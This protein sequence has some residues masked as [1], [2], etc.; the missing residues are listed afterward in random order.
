[1]MDRSI[2]VVDDNRDFAEL[3]GEVLDEE[4]YQVRVAFDGAAALAEIEHEHPDLVVSDVVMPRLDGPAL[5]RRLR[6]R[7]SHIP[8]VLL[9]AEY[10]DVDMPGVRFLRKPFELDDL[11]RLVARVIDDRSRVPAHAH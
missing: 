9:S 2:L 6:R 4:G 10:D 8:V 11:L 3:L 7:G 1:M 5:A